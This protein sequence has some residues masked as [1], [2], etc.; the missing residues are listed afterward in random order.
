MTLLETIQKFGPFTTEALW[1]EILILR[2]A[3]PHK[4]FPHSERALLIELSSMARMG[5]VQDTAEG[6]KATY[7]QI[8]PAKPQ[9][10]QKELF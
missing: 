3:S 5:V 9:D 7:R 6:W 2:K 8:E 4:D 10:Q 1:H